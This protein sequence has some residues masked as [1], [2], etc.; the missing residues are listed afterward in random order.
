VSIDNIEELGIEM[1]VTL[2]CECDTLNSKEFRNEMLSFNVNAK[3]AMKLFLYFNK[4]RKTNMREIADV[5]NLRKSHHF[6]KHVGLNCN[7][8]IVAR[9]SPI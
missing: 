7:I 3:D 4:V 6:L 9:L 8:K 2:F 5:K 1:L